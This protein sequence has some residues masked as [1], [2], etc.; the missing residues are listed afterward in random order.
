MTAM[1]T[2]HQDMPATGGESF[3][4]QALTRALLES[5][6]NAIM[7]EQADMACEGGVSSRNGYRERGPV[8]PAGKITLRIPK[9]RCGTYFPEGMLERCSRAD[10]AV[11][12]IATEM[13][14][15]GVSTRKVER[16]AQRMGIDRLPSSRVGRICKRL[17]AEV[18]ALRAR[19]FDMAMPCLFLDAAYVKRRR[20][21]R[22]QSAAVV[23][24]IAVGADGVRRVVGLSAIDAETYAG[25]LGFCRDLRTRGAG[26]VKRVTATPTRGCGA[27]SPNASPA[28][29]GSAAS[30]ASSATFARCCRLSASERPPARSCR[31]RSRRKAPPWCARPATPP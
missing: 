7:D 10:K 9:L 18:A 26:G 30:C 15:N 3:D 19:E 20:G 24:A 23:T 14:A 11:A 13:H 27:P 31:R 25:W 28:P 17:D 22:V 21:G 4:L 6:L 1:S 29:R 16:I 8:T 2:L 12:A 5:A